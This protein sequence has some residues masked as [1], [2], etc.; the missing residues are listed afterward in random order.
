MGLRQ[1]AA[2]LVGSRPPV[3]VAISRRDARKTCLVSGKEAVTE[4]SRLRVEF[5][6]PPPSVVHP[7]LASSCFGYLGEPGLA[8]RAAVG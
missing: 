5:V 2:I 7:A 6:A 4:P 3:K 1:D 8:P